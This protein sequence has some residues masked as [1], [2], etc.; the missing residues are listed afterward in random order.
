MDPRDVPRGYI[1]GLLQ[2]RCDGGSAAGH[3]G[4]RDG[5][6][7]AG[8]VLR[9]AARRPRRGGAARRPR[10]AVRSG[11]PDERA[12]YDV[13]ARGR[14]SVGLDLKHPEG[15]GRAAAPGR[16]GR[17]ADRGLP[18]RRDGA[19]RPRPRRLPR[20]QPAPGL[21]PHD[22]LGP[23][24]ARW[25]RPPATTSTT[26][27]SPARWTPSAAQGEPP[28]PPLNLVGDFGGGG[29]LLALG[30]LAA[31][32]ERAASGKGQVVDAAMVDGAALLMTI[33]YGFCCARR[34]G[35][36]RGT[37]LLDTGAH[38]YDGYETPTA[39]T[40]RSA[41]S[42]RSST[43][44]CVEAHAASSATK[45]PAQMDRT[46]WPRDEGAARRDLRDEDARRVVP[47]HGGHRR[48]LRAGAHDPGGVRAP[49]QPGARHLRR[50]RRRRAA[51][52]RAALQPHARRDRAAGRRRPASTPTRRSA[53]GDF[54]A[55][56]SASCAMQ[57]RW[58]RRGL[59]GRL[60][61]SAAVTH[62]GVTGTY[63]H[64]ERNPP[65][66][67]LL[68]SGAYVIRALGLFG[69]KYECGD[70]GATMF[71]RYESGLCPR[72]FNGQRAKHTETVVRDSPAR[73]RGVRGRGRR[74]EA[75][76][77]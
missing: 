25:R 47:D 15:V 44:S 33:I 31:L 4:D 13:L 55:R 75:D 61:A 67:P 2:E 46:Q 20:A 58:L 30:M 65:E 32:L 21:R 10:A 52:A 56:R 38:F 62:P 7:R 40:S 17:R 35:D 48:V 50:R 5:R 71:V 54:R 37:N 43:P 72:C 42:S 12:R 22:R 39:S 59:A 66:A 34:L 18:A 26:S 64:G 53:S 16:A 60:P 8:A 69:P 28:L 14:T 51:G 73:A 3:E 45:L 57:R 23:G 68:L 27:R 70:C 24:A 1:A 19:A 49:A 36:E 11:P 9:D 76:P 41:R 74:D 63:G 29:M 77:N 6:H